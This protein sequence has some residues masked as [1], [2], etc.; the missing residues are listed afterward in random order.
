MSYQKP[1][2]LLQNTDFTLMGTAEVE[3]Y[4][5]RSMFY[6][7]F[8]S[9]FHATGYAALYWKT[10]SLYNRDR[11]LFI[12]YI[13]IIQRL[14]AA[15]WEPITEAHTDNRV[16]YVERYGANYLTVFNDSTSAA[17]A[18]L[19]INVGR[20]WRGALPTSVTITDEVRETVLATVPAAPTI[21]IPLSL[22]GEQAT[23]LRLSP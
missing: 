10:P 22:K 12:K 6:G 7:C 19:T 2:L 18:T 5:Q 16:V 1:Y 17:T 13:P 20:F 11:S 14:S 8:P 3:K 23:A 9:M 21:A 15:G 4:F